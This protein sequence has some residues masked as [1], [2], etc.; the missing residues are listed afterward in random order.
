MEEHD[1]GL[2]RAEKSRSLPEKSL[3]RYSVQQALGKSPTFQ[4]WDMRLW[5]ALRNVCSFSRTVH[6]I[7]G[8]GFTQLPD[9]LH[10]QELD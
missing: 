6:S 9:T 4:N 1:F 3:Q 7:S 5:E 8:R 10:I 2:D